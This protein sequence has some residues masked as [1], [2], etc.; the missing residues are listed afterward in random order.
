[1]TSEER[2]TPMDYERTPEQINLWNQIEELIHQHQRFLVTAHVSPDGDAAGSSLALFGVLKSLG[3]D[4]VVFN[5]EP[6][7]H[8]LSQ[9]PLADQL[10]TSIP[11][12]TGFD[13]SFLCDCG[14]IERSPLRHLTPEQRGTVVVIDHHMT[15]GLEGDVNFNDTGAPCV[16]VLIFELAERL[17]VEFSQ[18]IAQNIYASLV[19]DTGGFRYQKTTPRA[20]R[21]AA[22]LL[23]T[24]VNPWTVASQLYESQ[25]FARQKLLAL[26]LETLDLNDTR[27]V[28]YMT[29][30][31]EMYDKTGATA[32]M[33]DGF[34]NFGRSVEG[35]EM[36]ILIRKQDEHFKL[37]LRSRGAANVAQ[38][39]QEFGGG[40]HKRAA[41]A[42]ITDMTYDELRARLETLVNDYFLNDFSVHS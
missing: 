36:S 9:F 17:G 16:G 41:G 13:V 25:P 22:R 40:G 14:E 15:S 28:A 33:S 26:A 20:F 1:M 5:D 4:V 7:D 27:Q 18:P 10:Q 12:E 11:A 23:E 29:L 39:A 42:V 34:V 24:G 19:S 31:Q 35:V 38:I 30:T 32:E 2:A 6:Y 21:M 3:K 8:K 37:S